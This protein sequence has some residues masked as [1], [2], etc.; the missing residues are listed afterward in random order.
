ME[1]K[2]L[3]VVLAI[4]MVVAGSCADPIR[5][6]ISGASDTTALGYVAGQS[7]TFHW[8]INELYAGNPGD[9]FPHIVQPVA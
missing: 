8:V 6:S 7:Y 2:R 5:I 9:F 4:V 3:T 1:L